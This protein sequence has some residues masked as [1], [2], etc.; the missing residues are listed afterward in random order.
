[1]IAAMCANPCVDRTAAVEKFTYGGMNRINEQRDDG[2]GKGV[3]VALA[4]RQLNLES[5]CLGFMPA[6]G[7]APILNRLRDSLCQT[8]FISCQGAVRVNL[9]LIDKSTGVIT[10]INESGPAVNTRQQEQLLEASVRWAVRCGYLVLTGSLP[11]GCP[12][13]YYR[14]VTTAVKQAAPRCRVVLDSEGDRFAEGLKAVPWMVKPN[15]FELELFCGRK[16]DTI[17]SIHAEALR[18]VDMGVSVV[19]VSMG[20]DGAYI[21]DG[22]EACW[23]PALSVPVK[24]ATGAGDSMVAGLLYGLEAG[25]PMAEAFRHG[26]AAAASSVTTEGTGLI[27]VLRYSEYLNRI[28]IRRVI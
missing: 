13:R 1:M 9:K 26:M 23:A 10:E 17:Q 28:D 22:R 15:R 21:T 6:E 3:N 27:D 8:D 4:C 20:G 16:L 14:D 5:V 24:S 19:A 25:L 11:P 2:S 7:N 12:V 18:I